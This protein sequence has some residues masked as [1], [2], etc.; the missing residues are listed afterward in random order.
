MDVKISIISDKKHV[1]LTLRDVDGLAAA[2]QKQA[3]D[4][5]ACNAVKAAAYIADQVHQRMNDTDALEI[6]SDNL[7][8]LLNSLK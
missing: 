5:P 1:A 3:P 6:S 2:A 4:T 8:D 7:G